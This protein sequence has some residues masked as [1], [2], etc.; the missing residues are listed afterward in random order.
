MM[1]VVKQLWFKI[2][3]DTVLSSL[4]EVRTWLS[5]IVVFFFYYRTV[6]K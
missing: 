3:S 5:S 2:Q 6:F 4:A 1:D